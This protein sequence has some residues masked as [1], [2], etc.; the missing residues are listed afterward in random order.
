[1][2]KIIAFIKSIPAKLKGWKKLIAFIIGLLS[3]LLSD[4]LSLSPE[5][6]ENIVYVVSAFLL[7]QGISDNGEYSKPSK[8]EEN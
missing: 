2:N 4:T 1:M 6:V 8:D 3:T 7:G 5:L